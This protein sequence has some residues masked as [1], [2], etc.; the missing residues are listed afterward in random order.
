MRKIMIAA[1]I[2]SAASFATPAST[3]QL[4][5]N[6][7]LSNPGLHARSGRAHLCRIHLEAQGYPS[8]YLHR[9]SSRGL[10]SAC[11]R[12]LWRKWKHPHA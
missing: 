5:P 6:A 8:S 1:L 7:D 9:R 11:S 4:A 10:V 3:M 2:L 12:S